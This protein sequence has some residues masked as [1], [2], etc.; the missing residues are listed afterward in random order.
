MIRK[1]FRG[2]KVRKETHKELKKEYPYYCPTCYENMYEFETYL[3]K[4]Q[5]ISC[6]ILIKNAIKWFDN[7]WK[8]GEFENEVLKLYMKE[9]EIKE[10][11]INWKK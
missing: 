1:C 4:G 11:D 3:E 7:L 6:K 10:N 5:K 2:H 8:T 9:F